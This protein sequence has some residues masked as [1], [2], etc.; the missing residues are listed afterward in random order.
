MCRSSSAKTGTAYQ[1]Y[2]RGRIGDA[3]NRTTLQP[4]FVYSSPELG[5]LRSVRDYP[6]P[7]HRNLPKGMPWA[8]RDYQ[9]DQG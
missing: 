1:I 6:E 5:C 7:K 9:P 2:E 4:Y 8:V 3:Y